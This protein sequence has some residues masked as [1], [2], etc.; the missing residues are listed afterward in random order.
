MTPTDPR[1]SSNSAASASSVR[2]ARFSLTTR[3]LRAASH[4]ARE[5]TGGSPALVAF[6]VPPFVMT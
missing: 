1:T 3:T 2:V 4:L 6:M 5:T